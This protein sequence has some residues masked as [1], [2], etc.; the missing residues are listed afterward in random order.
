MCSMYSKT[1][2]VT[3]VHLF[4]MKEIVSMKFSLLSDSYHPNLPM[5]GGQVM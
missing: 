4:N 5:T 2:T 1:F 3:G